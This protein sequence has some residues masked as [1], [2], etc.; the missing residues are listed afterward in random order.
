MQSFRTR[1]FCS[2]VANGYRLVSF[3]T[4]T[5]WRQTIQGQFSYKN[6]HENR[7]TLSL[8]PV[9]SSI[10]FT[11]Y[12]HYKKGPLQGTMWEPFVKAVSWICQLHESSSCFTKVFII[13][14]LLSVYAEQWEKE[15]L[16]F[17][18]RRRSKNWWKNLTLNSS[19]ASY[20]V[21][22]EL[23]AFCVYNCR[24]CLKAHVVQTVCNERC[25]LVEGSQCSLV[26]TIP[27]HLGKLVSCDYLVFSLVNLPKALVRETDYLMSYN[28]GK[29]RFSIQPM[30]IFCT[31]N[32][33]LG[34]KLSF[35]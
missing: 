13:S 16:L 9:C 35:L 23:P 8:R 2:F 19:A 30:W 22:I 28:G 12:I 7:E 14:S 11:A 34:E 20:R 3:P 25:W 24:R 6:D 5:L 4:W 29:L 27:A 10:L 17:L 21:F 15:S 18:E 32:T 26:F 1:L 31:Y 33:F